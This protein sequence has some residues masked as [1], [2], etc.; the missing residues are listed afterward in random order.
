VTGRYLATKI[1][2]STF[3]RNNGC[4]VGMWWDGVKRGYAKFGQCREDELV[5]NRLRRK[6]EGQLA[7]PGSPGMMTVNPL[8]A[9]CRIY[10]AQQEYCVRQLPDISG[11]I[12]LDY[13]GTWHI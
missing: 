1:C 10:P 9:K 11:D 8:T 2:T 5:R 7:N 3:L 4:R 12:C 6:V 13:I